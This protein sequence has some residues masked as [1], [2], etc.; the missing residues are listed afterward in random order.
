MS[1]ESKGVTESLRA[2]AGFLV[3]E[4]ALDATLEHVSRMG[5][6]V[7]D[8]ADFAGITMYENGKLST[9]VYTDE[10]SPQVDQTQYEAGR[11]PCV[12]A[13][14]LGTMMLMES[15]DEEDRWPEFAATAADHGVQSVL[16]LPL[17]AGEESL[18]A[19]NFYSRDK[20]AYSSDA[21]KAADM[22]AAQAAIVLANAQTCWGTRNLVEQLQRAVE[23]RDVIGQAKGILMAR[24]W[25]SPDD[26]F[27]MLKRASQ[28]ENRKLVDI[29][30][31]IVQRYTRPHHTES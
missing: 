5:V 25:C 23:S 10:K 20:Y 26:A 12:D 15:V 18:G 17:T 9:S 8:G 14:R 19:L 4:V 2:L 13:M 31:D 3:G 21:I 24:E 22:F 11:G 16:S 30:S 27:E 28:R 1:E 6:N 29:A 7:V